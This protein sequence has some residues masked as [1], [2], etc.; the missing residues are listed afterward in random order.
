M[1]LPIV[2]YGSKILRSKAPDIGRDDNFTE[3][4]ENM[5]LTLKNQQGYGL[6]G[7]QVNVLKNIF[8]ID[9]TSVNEEGTEPAVKTYFNPEILDY[10]TDEVYYNEGCLSIP[11]IYEDVIRPDKIEVRYRDENFDVKEETLGGMAARIFQHEYD[12]LQGILFIDRL[13]VLRKKM[14]NSKLKQIAR[15]SII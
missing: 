14:I 10:N 4:A 12:H 1:I 5:I 11:G 8:I 15:R 6:A 3:L 13:S 7:P 2:L 9:T